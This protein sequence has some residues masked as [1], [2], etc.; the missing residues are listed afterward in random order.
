MAAPAVELTGRQRE[1][2]DTARALLAR[3]GVDALSLGSVAKSLPTAAS[4]S[5]TR[6]STG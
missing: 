2:V 3:D 1:I 6:S 5:P 4:R